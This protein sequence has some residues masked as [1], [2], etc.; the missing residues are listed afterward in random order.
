VPVAGAL[1]RYGYGIGI[2][3]NRI[4]HTEL[5]WIKSKNK[6]HEKIIKQAKNNKNQTASNGHDGMIEANNCFMKKCFC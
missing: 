4:T 1:P 3:R 2:K 6:F 5:W